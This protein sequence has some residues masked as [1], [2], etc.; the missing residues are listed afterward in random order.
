TC[1]LPIFPWQCW[2]W[3]S[4]FSPHQKNPAKHHGANTSP[5]RHIDIFFFIDRYLQGS[6]IQIMGIFCKT[7]STVGKT[8]STHHYQY[9]CGNSLHVHLF[10][11]PL[12]RIYVEVQIP[13]PRIT[14]T[15]RTTTAITMSM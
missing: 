12:N 15:S 4:F 10:F 11:L 8:Q 3:Q 9:D 13:L 1:A 14:R 5:H 6:H 2:P 7:E